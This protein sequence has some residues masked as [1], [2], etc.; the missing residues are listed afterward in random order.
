MNGSASRPNSATMNGTRCAIIHPGMSFLLLLMALSH[1]PECSGLPGG[2]I[3]GSSATC[4]TFG[5][6]SPDWPG[7]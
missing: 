6:T 3:A 5:F 1:R 7:C 4:G 2:L